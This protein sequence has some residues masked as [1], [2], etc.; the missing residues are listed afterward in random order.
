MPR[1]KQSWRPPG[2][3]IRVQP[4]PTPW[5]F[6]PKR[7]HTSFSVFLEFERL[8]PLQSVFYF[9]PQE[10]L[11]WDD[12]VVLH[13]VSNREVKTEFGMLLKRDPAS[14]PSVEERQRLLRRCATE[15]VCQDQSASLLECLFLSPGLVGEDKANVLVSDQITELSPFQRFEQGS[16]VFGFYACV[17]QFEYIVLKVDQAKLE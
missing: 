1:T 5:V 12:W 16:S 8:L 4:N 2:G 13:E 3:F 10:T 17:L 11:D 14:S 15:S 7:T 6:A 9:F